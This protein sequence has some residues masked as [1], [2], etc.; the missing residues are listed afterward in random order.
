MCEGLSIVV[1]V[2][3]F[4]IVSLSI[5]HAMLVRRRS[6]RL[7][8][9]ERDQ[10]EAFFESSPTGLVVFDQNRLIVK[11]NA[12]AASLAVGDSSHMLN[13]QHGVALHCAHSAD[14]AQGCG[15]SRQCQLCPLK[16]VIETVIGEGKTLRNV[17][18][19]LVVVRDGG[20]RSI[21]LRLGAEPFD[22]AGRRHVI[23]AVDDVSQQKHLADKLQLSSTELERMNEEIRN[24]NMAK[25][26][27]LA[28]MSHEI[29]T[30]LNGI[31]GMTGLLVETALTPEQRDYASTI[32]SSSEALLQIV[33]DIL[34]I[35]KIEANKLVLENSVF[36]LKQCLEDVIR[37]M[38]PTAAKKRLELVYRVDQAICTMCIGDTGRIRQ[39]LLNLVG[40]ALKFTERGEIVVTASGRPLDDERYQLEFSVRD[41]GVGILPEQQAR[42]FQSFSQIDNSTTRRF[43]GAGLGLAI[44]KRLCELMGGTLWVES[45]GIPGQGSDFRFTIVVRGGA[46]RLTPSITVANAALAKKRV[47]L[48]DEHAQTREMLAELVM[49]WDMV[50]IVAVSASGALGLLR[51]HEPVDVAV[52]DNDLSD[53]SGPHMAKAVHALPGRA[54]LKIVRLL[55]LGDRIAEGAEK[56]FVAS[57][58]KPVTAT[59]LQDALS[60]ALTA[61]G[62]VSPQAAV[63]RPPE[64]IRRTDE[65][66]NSHPLRL[67]LAEDHLVNQKVALALLGRLGYRADVAE[68]GTKVLE[69]LGRVTYDVVFMD[70]QMPELDGEQTTL[71]IRKELPVERQPWIIAMTANAIKG[72]RERYLSLGMNDYIPKP[73]RMERLVEVLRAAKPE[74]LRTSY[75]AQGNE[76]TATARS[77]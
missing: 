35:S 48:V 6:A 77:V 69:S 67:L 38:A 11:L 4:L 50:P 54:E 70:V 62:S 8:Q 22:L 10:L 5:V 2:C 55:R 66:A 42:L 47:L 72:D 64:G 49:G 17:E 15:Y 31:M 19:P 71:R 58:P 59:Q 51:G 68:D 61:R 7:I 14:H 1:I 36:D 28:H 30:P 21:W 52:I 32:Y 33:N 20:L 16:K 37:V 40:N 9:V 76:T 3:M 56:H 18:V 75:G 44:S 27:F 24:S 57:V 65:L 25:S 12:A 45:K 26:M 63:P 23:V 39:V 41:K 73:I 13:R 43:G 46:C 34:D 74:S 53:M 60:E 29:R